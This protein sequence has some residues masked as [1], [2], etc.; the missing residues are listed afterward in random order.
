MSGVAKKI[1]MAANIAIIIAALGFTVFVVRYYTA[2]RSH[3]GIS[4]GTK[5]GVQNIQWQDNKKNIVLGLSTECHFC[6]ESAG[7]YRELVQQCKQEHVR[8]IALLPQ[9]IPAAQEY[10]KNEGVQV[11]EIRQ[12]ALPDVGITGTPTLLMVSDAGLVKNVW[13]GKLPENTEKE[14]LAKVRQ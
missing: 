12:A 4:V 3:Q 11:D 6:T 1:E 8:T 5:F 14:V 7:F 2:N 9:P 13:I 10:L